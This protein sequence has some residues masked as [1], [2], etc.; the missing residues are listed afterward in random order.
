MER[1]YREGDYWAESCRAIRKTATLGF[2]GEEFECC[3]LGGE[4]LFSEKTGK[5]GCCIRYVSDDYKLEA[6]F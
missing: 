3:F 5:S 1:Y 6:M 4:E 2:L